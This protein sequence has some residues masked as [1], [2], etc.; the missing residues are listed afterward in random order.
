MKSNMLYNF[1][2]DAVVT[3]PRVVPHLTGRARWMALTMKGG[4]GS[5]NFGHAGRPGLVGGSA[6]N[7]SNVH[8]GKNKKENMRLAMEA[9]ES[10]GVDARLLNKDDPQHIRDGIKRKGAAYYSSYPVEE[11]I[12]NPY[13][14]FWD[15]P[16]A[17][18]D[19]NAGR[20]AS[21][22]PT[23]V[24]YHE[25]AHYKFE[26][27]GSDEHNFINNR[28]FRDVVEREVS[29]Y[30]AS[31]VREFVAEVY[32]G[33]ATGK[34]Y[35]PF[36]MSKY[37]EYRH[38]KYRRLKEEAS[39][40]YKSYDYML[41][42]IERLV[43]SLYNDQIAGEFVDVMAN[44]ISGQLWDAY[45][46]AWAEEGTGG[47][48]PE[49]LVASYDAAVLAQYSFVDQYYRD[50]VDARLD[51]TPLEPL[52]ARAQLWANRWNEAYNEAVRLIT[53]DSGGNLE[54]KLGATEE[55]CPECAAL[56]GMVARAS[57]WDILGVKPQNAPNSKISCE[58]WR[59]DCSLLPTKKRRSPG[60]YGRIEEILMAKA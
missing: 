37:E 48:V 60:A 6:P 44:L 17:Y 8:F 43:R 34:E 26:D 56:D 27:R 3:V 21:T 13:N 52:I 30:A 29:S 24:L 16:Q 36:I 38:E 45:S 55:H 54:W 5:G 20:F 47:E 28:E 14:D 33:A 59:C 7:F 57:D 46:K 19:R 32:A 12:I 1:I 41:T 58:G 51:K 4:E 53:V 42:Q 49:Y 15:D 50:I 25:Y 35:S 31:N 18:A 9:W 39:K 2:R 10:E 22:D 40:A 11:I 23:R